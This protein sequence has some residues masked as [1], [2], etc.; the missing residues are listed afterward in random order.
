MK[1]RT[2]F[3]L[4]SCEGQI[5]FINF[6]PDMELNNQ[7]IKE[8]N[9]IAVHD[10]KLEKYAMVVDIRGNAYTTPESRKFSADN[11][12][13]KNHIAYGIV[14]SSIAEKLRVNF[15]I[16]FNRPKVPT[17]MFTDMD[18]C[19]QWLNEKITESLSNP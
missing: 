13:V 16:D 8:L 14:V 3:G 2:R 10:F 7:D 9:D 17:R 6:T 5:L 18:E 1:K 12:Y 15:F 19:I 11:P 4:L